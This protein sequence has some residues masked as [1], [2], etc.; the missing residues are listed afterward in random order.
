[1]ARPTKERIV[2]NPPLYTEF[3]PRG[4]SMKFIEE[5]KLS[6]DE[7]EALRL[8]DYNG[9]SQ[10]EA[11]EEMEISRPTFTRLIEIAR[12]KIAD[13][14]INGKMLTIEGGNI[15]FRK[16]I[17]KCDN[18]GY[19]FKINF[20]TKFVKCPECSSNRL[21]NLAEGFGHGNCCKNKSLKNIGDNYE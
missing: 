13:F 18:C 7:Y 16:N 3:K 17:I 19:M 14:I 20:G 12:K 21:I 4:V 8:S 15:H 10:E 9:L 11:A 5:I 6:L 1:M 2:N